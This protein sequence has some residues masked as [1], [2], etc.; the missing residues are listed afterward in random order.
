M[1]HIERRGGLQDREVD[2]GVVASGR[3][4]GRVRRKSHGCRVQVSENWVSD[5]RLCESEVDIS[6]LLLFG[7]SGG[8]IQQVCETHQSQNIQQQ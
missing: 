5:R 7:V 4:R 3:G 2:G 1:V 6:L 8:S